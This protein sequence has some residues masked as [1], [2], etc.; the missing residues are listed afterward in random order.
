MGNCKPNHL[1]QPFVFFQST[2]DNY[3]SSTTYVQTHGLRQ[4]TANIITHYNSKYEDSSL[5]IYIYSCESQ[6]DTYIYVHMVEKGSHR[7]VRPLN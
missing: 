7:Y 2:I 6:I 3:I 4:G 1:N 5:R